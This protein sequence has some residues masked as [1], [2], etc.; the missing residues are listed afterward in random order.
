[1]KLQ[2]DNSGKNLI[3]VK[4]LITTIEKKL[5]SFENEKF[6]VEKLDSN[7]LVDFY[8]ILTKCEIILSKYESKKTTYQH[9]KKFVDILNSTIESLET[10]DGKITELS[11]SADFS[12]KKIKEFES[13]YLNSSTSYHGS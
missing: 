13:Q 9:M 6:I 10:M 8:K 5:S 4:E 1:M 7:E 2:K 11:V 12:M 3:Q